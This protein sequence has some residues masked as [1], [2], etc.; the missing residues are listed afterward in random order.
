MAKMK[1]GRL[2]AQD[3]GQ[4]DPKATLAP[5]YRRAPCSA[6]G[7]GHVAR[8]DAGA[9][10][11]E[12]RGHAAGDVGAQDAPRSQAQ[13]SR[14][15][16]KVEAR[17]PACCLWNPARNDT[18]RQ[19]SCARSRQ[20]QAPSASA[21][22]GQSARVARR[23]N[24]SEGAPLA[25]L[26]LPA[27]TA[28]ASALAI[29]ER[30]A[31]RAPSGRA[32]SPLL[33]RKSALAPSP[34]SPGLRARQSVARRASCRAHGAPARASHAPKH[35]RLA[36]AAPGSAATGW[37]RPP[38][39]NRARKRALAPGAS[40]YPRPARGVHRRRAAPGGIRKYSASIAGEARSSAGR[41]HHRP[42]EQKPVSQ[43]ST[44]STN[45]VTKPI[46]T[47]ART[48]RP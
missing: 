39:R 10:S 7:R 34:H 44:A 8:S 16:L 30:E 20:A 12:E 43:K 6:E 24:H 41:T 35:G 23:G 1:L 42:A 26:A 2:A 3:L 29:A 22:V 4:K 47:A 18:A 17:S 14:A 15:C 37:V 27:P 40:L 31:A 13:E 21:P 32:V 38:A 25:A 11:A 48:A 45:G 5:R 33:A 36:R 19:A 46:D 9:C 28:R